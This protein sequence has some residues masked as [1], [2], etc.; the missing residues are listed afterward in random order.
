MIYY[1]LLVAILIRLLVR[2]FSTFCKLFLLLFFLASICVPFYRHFFAFISYLS[3]LTFFSCL[4]I[5][6]YRFVA[7]HFDSGCKHWWEGWCDCIWMDGLHSP[8]WGA[9]SLFCYLLDFICRWVHMKHLIICGV[10]GIYIWY[11]IIQVWFLFGL[12]LLTIFFLIWLSEYV[13]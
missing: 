3:F 6:T 5:F 13:A 10:C 8:I 9:Y 4:A 2:T 7:C 12:I 1:K 11:C